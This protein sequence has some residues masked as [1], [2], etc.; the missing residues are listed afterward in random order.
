[1]DKV[2]NAIDANIPKNSDL[3]VKAILNWIYALTGIVAVGFIVYG[4]VNYVMSQGEPGKIKQA[5][6]TI[7][8]AVIGLIVVLLAAA[9]T[10]F[11]IGAI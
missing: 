1:M 7:V 10:N 6:Q 9:L 3:D 4:A 8:F 2:K 11:V 5:S